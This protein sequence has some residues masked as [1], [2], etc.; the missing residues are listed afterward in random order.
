MMRSEEEEGQDF[1]LTEMYGCDTVGTFCDTMRWVYRLI[2]G[3]IGLGCRR[4]GCFDDT[5][6]L[7]GM[8]ALATP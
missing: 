5:I 3:K 7:T 1:L 4:S 8:D 2:M 6:R